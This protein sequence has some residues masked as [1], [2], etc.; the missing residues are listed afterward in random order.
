MINLGLDFDNT[1]INYDSLF[2]KAASEKK[3]IPSNF[4][5]SK[6]LIRDY[7]REKGLEDKFTLLQGE[8]YGSRITEAVQSEGMFKA[9]KDVQ[10]KGVNLFIVSHKTK[11]P[12][13]GPKF[14]LHEAALSWL[15]KNMFFDKSGINIPKDNVFFEVTKE[16]KINRILSI[17]CTH[18][19]DDLP[20][21]LE[22]IDPRIIK[23]LYS[24]LSERISDNKVIYM[25]NWSNLNKIID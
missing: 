18:F 24:P 22:M 12:Y 7:L 6:K 14:D 10:K 13:S 17:G 3:L 2:Q 11:E 15:E 4:P 1:L 19:I 9:L 20:E 8:V 16:K 25:N 23:I 5:K 21:I